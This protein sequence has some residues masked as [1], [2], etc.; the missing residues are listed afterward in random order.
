MLF[1]IIPPIDLHS[2]SA[3]CILFFKSSFFCEL[4]RA[5]INVPRQQIRGILL[6]RVIDDSCL[7]YLYL[8]HDQHTV[9]YM[10]TKKQRGHIKKLVIAPPQIINISLFYVSQ[11]PKV[12]W[13]F[14]HVS[15][16][17]QFMSCFVQGITAQREIGFSVNLELILCWTLD[18]GGETRNFFSS[19]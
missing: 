7:F 19:Q 16:I 15:F 1:I 14:C 2:L 4:V 13:P 3:N 11:L 18:F 10:F 6:F 5:T 17:D 9:L 8:F 12:V